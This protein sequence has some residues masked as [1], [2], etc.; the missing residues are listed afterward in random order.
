MVCLVSYYVQLPEAAI[1]V[2]GNCG[3]MFQMYPPSLSDI[4]KAEDD[5]CDQVGGKSLAII[6]M[7]PL[8]GE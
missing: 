2:F 7:I 4:R 6:N 3:Y 8:S 5:I 1:G